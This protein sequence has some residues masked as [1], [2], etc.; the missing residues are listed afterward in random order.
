MKNKSTII[1]LFCAFVFIVFTAGFLFGRT[2]GAGNVIVSYSYTPTLA[3]SEN[4]FADIENRININ[5]ADASLLCELP[6]IG[7]A[8]AQRI[9]T[10]R[11]E[12]GNFQS[13]EDLTHVS[14]I[15]EKI[16]QSL[17]DLITVGG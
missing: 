15:G 9:I 12:N 5:T 10:Y 2:I 14:G 6:G 1:P 8:L 17:A 7:P 13:I 3:T 4:L 16:L 11:N